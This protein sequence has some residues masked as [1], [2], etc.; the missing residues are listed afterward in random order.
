MLP[1]RVKTNWPDAA[2]VSSVTPGLVATETIVGPLAAIWLVT[3]T[4]FWVS[5]PCTV[6]AVRVTPLDLVP[7]TKLS[8]VRPLTVTGWLFVC[9]RLP[10]VTRA[11]DVDPRTITGVA[12]AKASM[13]P[14]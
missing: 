10:P 6:C 11:S 14:R 4:P 13:S 12:V 2:P 9:W 1:V 8:T 5:W 3:L 7:A